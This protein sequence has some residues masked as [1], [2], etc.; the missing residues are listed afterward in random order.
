[1]IIKERS[2]PLRAT[3]DEILLRRLPQNHP[4]RPFIEADFH[5]KDAGYHGERAL[6]YPLSFLPDDQ[7]LIIQNIR[8]KYEKWYFQMDFLLLSSKFALILEAKNLTGS[9][10]FEASFNQ[11][12]Q[13]CK[14]QDKSYEDPTAQAE[15][16]QRLLALWLKKYFPQADLPI[17]YLVVMSNPNAILKADPQNTHII[18]KVCKPYKLLDRIKK[19][20]AHFQQERL[21]AKALKKA[22]KLLVKHHT[23][24]QYDI[25]NEYQIRKENILPGV[26][27]PKCHVLCMVY[28]RGMWHCLNCGARSKDAHLAGLNDYFSLFPSMTNAQCKEFLHLPS[29]NVA[30]KIL[31]TMQLPSSGRTKDRIYFQKKV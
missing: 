7:Y 15:R 30:Q 28:S 22:G 11:L 10:H 21:D 13:T 20:E 17:D 5:R 16:Q 23:L 25:L 6:D 18:Q 19:I 14:D 9:L 1:M 29:G 2:Y 4:K 31:L 12:I 8:L 27:C 26:Q 24:K 3:L